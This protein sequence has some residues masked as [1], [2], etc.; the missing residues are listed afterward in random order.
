MSDAQLALLSHD[1][2]LIERTRAEMHAR[3]A[4]V[5]LGMLMASGG[6]ALSSAG[7]VL[8]GQ[9]KLPQQVT[10]PIALGGL[11]VG[12]AGLLVVTNSIQEPL[13][14]IS[15]RRP[16]TACRGKKFASWWRR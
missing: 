5:Y 2:E 1:D 4:W 15:R 11:A 8:Y 14:P 13:E 16:C 12:V 10:L 6:T 9:D 7:W 3:G